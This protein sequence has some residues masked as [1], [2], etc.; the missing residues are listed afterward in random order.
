MCEERWDI[1]TSIHLEIRG[2]G[3][4]EVC[5]TAAGHPRSC[6]T[7]EFQGPVAGDQDREGFE[8]S[9]FARRE[10]LLRCLSDQVCDIVLRSIQDAMKK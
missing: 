5:G 2:P 7:A 9:V 8:V 6:G 10:R 1:G 4:Q 3:M